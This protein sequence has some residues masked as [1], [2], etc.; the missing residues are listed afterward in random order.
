MVVPKTPPICRPLLTTALP[1][2]LS[3]AG[4]SVVAEPMTVGTENPNPMPIRNQA[5][6]MSAA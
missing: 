5:G 1:V 6:S 3:F 2:A 4:R